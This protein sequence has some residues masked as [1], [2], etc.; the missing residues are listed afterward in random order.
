MTSYRK[1][2]NTPGKRLEGIE[3]AINRL[4]ACL[5]GAGQLAHHELDDLI[6][7]ADASDLATSK[8]LAKALALWIPLHGADT[9][10]HTAA[11]VIATAAAWTSA[12]DDPADLTEVQNILNELKADWNGHIADASAHR[13]VFAPIDGNGVLTPQA[14]T[15][16]DATNQGTANA[17]ANAIKAYCNNHAES[18]NQDIQLIRS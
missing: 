13:G 9:D 2:E 8:A 5:A 12:P 7:T 4:N 15:T 18:A 10:V 1:V 16:A 17:L 3:A 11:D 6:T 14:I